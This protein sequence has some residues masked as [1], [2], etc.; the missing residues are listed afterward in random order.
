F[1]RASGL[2]PNACTFSF[3]MTRSATALQSAR[4]AFLRRAAMSESAGSVHTQEE[5]AWKLWRLWQQGQRPDVRQFLSQA[6]GTL[7]AELVPVLRV[8]QR[9]RWHIGERIAAESYLDTYPVLKA[10]REQGVDLVYGEFLL[11]EELGETPTLEEYLKR[12]PQY[13]DLLQI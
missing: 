13:A 8:D 7:P 4:R 12:F 2:C 6:G 9:E 11:R 5:P 10:D 1:A 3:A